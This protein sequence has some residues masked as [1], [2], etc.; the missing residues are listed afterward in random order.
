MQFTRQIP[1]LVGH[2]TEKRRGLNGLCSASPFPVGSGT[3]RMHL[4][5][6]TTAKSRVIT[7]DYLRKRRLAVVVRGVDGCGDTARTT[8]YWPNSGSHPCE[9]R[10]EP[11]KSRSL[12][13][14]C[15]GSRT[16]G[17]VTPKKLVRSMVRAPN[18]K[19]LG[20]LKGG[21]VKL[22]IVPLS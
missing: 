21:K 15:T 22:K 12:S 8:L 3:N 11:A 19:C 9:L 16:S 2:L 13:Y 17:R 10:I 4:M 20:S 1:R 18:S 5:K 14:P 7:R 6:I